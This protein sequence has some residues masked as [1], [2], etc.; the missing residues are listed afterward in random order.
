MKT[1]KEKIRLAYGSTLMDG[2]HT[3]WKKETPR[4]T[5][6]KRLK[7][8]VVGGAKDSVGFR[9]DKYDH[10]LFSTLCTQH[11]ERLKSFRL[12][13]QYLGF[14]TWV[15]G[16]QVCFDLVEWCKTS[17]EANTLC[18]KRGQ[19]AYYDVLNKKDI[20]PTK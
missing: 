17:E 9:I 1:Q 2:G 10:E 11:H 20:Y 8:Y 6:R 5:D 16:G 13:H 3:T 4:R 14:G 19:K 12:P 18:L 7:G 15:D